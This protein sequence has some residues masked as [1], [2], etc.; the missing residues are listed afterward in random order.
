M[1]SHEL[2]EIEALLG[3]SMKR[4]ERAVSNMRELAVSGLPTS[5]P[6]SHTR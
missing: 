2:V 6:G 3:E 1:L 4:V 5:T